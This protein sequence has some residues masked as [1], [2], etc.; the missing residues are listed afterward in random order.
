VVQTTHSGEG[1]GH[2]GSVGP[3]REPGGY[4]VVQT[5]L[6]GRVRATGEVSVGP[7][8][9]PGGCLRPTDRASLR[10]GRGIPLGE[11]HLMCGW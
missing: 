7:V 9:E 5:T 3:V 10:A 2:R 11:G 4:L 8:R 6:V 1:K